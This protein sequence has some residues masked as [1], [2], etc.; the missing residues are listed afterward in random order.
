MTKRVWLGVLALLLSS[1]AGCIFLLP[2][3]PEILY[4]EDFDSESSWYVGSNDYRTWWIE[5]GEYHLL[6]KYEDIPYH[7]R[8]RQIGDLA[9]YQL[10][11]DTRQLGGPDDNSYG[12]TFRIRDSENLYRFRI[13]GDGW[14]RFDKKVNDNYVVIRDWE[15]SALVNQGNSANHITIV[16]NGSLF[17]FYVNGSE[18]YSE[19][20]HEFTSGH[21]GVIAAMYDSPGQT[22]IAFDNLIIQ[23]LE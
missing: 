23:A 4:N 7:S 16:A 14:V 21:A 6:I 12:V 9:D 2:I 5:G 20:D 10:D 8:N 11:V 18:A 3:E 1:L 15:R 17:T 19:T 13:S 22:H